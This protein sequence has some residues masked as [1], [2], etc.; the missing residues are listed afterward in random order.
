MK[1]EFQIKY[2]GD[3]VFLLGMKLDR[4]ASGIFLH[5]SQYIQRKLQLPDAY[6]PLDQKSYLS[7]ASTTDQE[8]FQALNINYQAIIGSLNYLRILTRPNISF[9]VSKLSQFLENP[10][11]THYTAALKVLF[12]LKGTMFCRLNFRNQSS[13][14][15]QSFIDADW[16]NCPDTRCSHTG[17]LVLR[18][19]HL[20]SWKST[21]Q[22][23]VSLSTTKAEYKVLTN[24]CKDVIWIQILSSEILP[25]CQE[26]SAVVHIDNRGTINLALS[27][28]SQ[29]GFRTKQIDLQ[30]HFICD[31]IARKL[32]KITHVSGLKNFADFLTKPVGKTII[33]RAISIFA[34][35]TPS[36]SAL[37]SQARGMRACQNSYSVALHSPD[38]IMQ[39]IR[40]ELRLDALVQ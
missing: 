20:I 29:N 17:F 13:F 4:V 21:K 2:M 1:K 12:F 6:C 33:A 32:I 31:L 26:S 30:L 5:Q 7:K 35:S 34:T 15:L 27:Q 38:I 25:G 9:S 11:L 24:A 37:C 8:C 36:I 3:A 16:A 22:A 39:S 23:T 40:D 28:V 18:D 14:N 10:G 19:S